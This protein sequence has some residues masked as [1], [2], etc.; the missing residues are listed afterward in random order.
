MGFAGRLG[1][2]RPV[3]IEVQ[4]MAARLIPRL[5]A[6]CSELEA[7]EAYWVGIRGDD[8]FPPRERLDPAEI[9]GFLPHI[10][11][12]DVLDDPRDFRYRL[13]GEAVIAE[14][15]RS[16][17]GHTV[18][19]LIESDP[20]QRDMFDLYERVTRAGRPLFARVEYENVRGAIK[21]AMLGV[22]PLGTPPKVSCLLAG[23]FFLDALPPDAA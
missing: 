22:F 6:P 9:R 20:D 5:E 11:L 21:S 4:R 15:A 23:I 7:L 18:S 2:V 19:E 14:N 16:L 1:K 17:K 10:A 13:M 3:M 8:P 12:V